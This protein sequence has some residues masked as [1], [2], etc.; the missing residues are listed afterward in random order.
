[1]KKQKVDH[2]GYIKDEIN[3]YLTDDTS[4]DT[5]YLFFSTDPTDANHY[6]IC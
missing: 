5:K 1:M 6:P 2:F 4:D 3:N